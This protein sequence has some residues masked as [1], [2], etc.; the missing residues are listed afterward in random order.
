MTQKTL[1]LTF[2]I[3]CLSVISYAQTTENIIAVSPVKMNILYVGVKNPLRVAVSTYSAEQ[4][5]I[6]TNKGRLE[7]ISAG[8]YILQIE[9]AEDIDIQIFGKGELLDTIWFRG[10]QIPNPVATVG[11]KGGGNVL[12][13]A[14]LDEEKLSADLVEFPFDV[15]FEIIS[16]TVRYVENE[17]NEEKHVFK[18]KSESA[19]FTDAQ[20]A[21]IETAKAGEKIY[22]ENINAEAPD[23]TIRNL[24]PI[25]FTILQ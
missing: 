10:Q 24:E 22:I 8:N 5:E 23:G 17:D 16:F 4:I 14:L 3:F 9:R 2:L 21:L 12:K 13:N 7:K 11:E 6:R 1:F 25:T 19:Y 15:T 18:A 20:K